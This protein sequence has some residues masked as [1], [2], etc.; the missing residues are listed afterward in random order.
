MVTISNLPRETELE[1]QRLIDSGKFEDSTSVVVQ[2]IRILAE[3]REHAEKLHDL[4]KASDEQF[5]RGEFQEFTQ[6]RRNYLKNIALEKLRAAHHSNR[7][8]Q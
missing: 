4:L 8:A 2:A 3:E 1:I 5:D 7:H 6:E